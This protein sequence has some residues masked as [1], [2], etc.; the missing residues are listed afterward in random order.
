MGMRT[1][2]VDGDTELH[3][4][5]RQRCHRG[6]GLQRRRAQATSGQVARSVHCFPPLPR[7]CIPF[8]LP[9]CPCQRA[10]H[11]SLYGEQSWCLLPTIFVSLSFFLSRVSLGKY[12][13]ARAIS[14]LGSAR[15]LLTKGVRRMLENFE[16]FLRRPRPASSESPAARGTPVTSTSSAAHG[17]RHKFWKVLSSVCIHSKCTRALTFENVFQLCRCRVS[18]AAGL[19][20]CCACA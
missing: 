12:M 8:M 14:S 10:R 13:C 11:S 5:G 17:A 16:D 15:F 18:G 3:A 7:V 19:L 6:P 9:S 20:R 2:S 4:D 1:G